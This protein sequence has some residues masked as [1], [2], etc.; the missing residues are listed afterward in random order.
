[1]IRK[2]FS[3]SFVSDTVEFLLLFW[4][5]LLSY[6]HSIAG[7]CTDQQPLPANRGASFPWL[8]AAFHPPNRLRSP[9][10]ALSHPQPAPIR[11]VAHPPGFP[12]ARSDN[13]SQR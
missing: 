9:S 8:D 11:R 4:K 3:F 2:I 13:L 1:M 6:G 12:S 5:T 7:R 10:S